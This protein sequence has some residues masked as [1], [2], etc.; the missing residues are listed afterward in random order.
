MKDSFDQHAGH[1]PRPSTGWAE[2][3]QSEIERGA[4]RRAQQVRGAL[5]AGGQR[6]ADRREHDVTLP[7]R[8]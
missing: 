2:R 4:Q 6:D 1:R 8:E 3:R 5:D 7:V